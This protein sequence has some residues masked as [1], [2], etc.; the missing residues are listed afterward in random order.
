[1]APAPRGEG[2]IRAHPRRAAAGSRPFDLEQLHATGCAGPENHA[3]PGATEVLCDERDQFLV[4][5]AVHRRSLHPRDPGAIRLRLERR[6]PGV[7]FHSDSQRDPCHFTSAAS[8]SKRSMSVTPR[9]TRCRHLRA[10]VLRWRTMKMTPIR[11]KA[12]PIA[13]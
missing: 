12:S 10:P 1:A 2:F 6:R 13:T 4:G 3:G 8:G 9:V 5:L 7:G 11:A